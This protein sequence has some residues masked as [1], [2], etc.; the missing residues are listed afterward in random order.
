MTA[1]RFGRARWRSHVSNSPLVRSTL[2]SS[3]SCQYLS[4]LCRGLTRINPN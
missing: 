1:L 3:N 2:D 4:V